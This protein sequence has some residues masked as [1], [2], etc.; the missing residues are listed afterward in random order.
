MAIANPVPSIVKQ[1]IQGV[2]S[3][4]DYNGDDYDEEEDLEYD[5]DETTKDN[6]LPFPTVH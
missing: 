2:E 1:Y 4:M 5:S 6:V 3:I